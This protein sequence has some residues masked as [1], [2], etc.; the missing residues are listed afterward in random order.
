MNCYK[1]NRYID[2]YN[3]NLM[4]YPPECRKFHFKT[5]DFNGFG[6]NV[7]NP[8]KVCLYGPL[9]KQ[10]VCRLHGI[11]KNINMYRQE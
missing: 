11:Y 4:K 9:T 2:A 8:P 1:Y 6:G 5:P 10:I 3:P 7:P